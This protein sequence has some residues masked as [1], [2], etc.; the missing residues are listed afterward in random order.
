[1][2]TVTTV[3]TAENLLLL[4]QSIIEGVRVVK[5]TDKEV[6]YRSL[7]EMMQIRNLM[8]AKLGLKKCGGQG[9]FGGRRLTAKTS[10]GLDDC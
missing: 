3:F 8:R 7:D 4:E 2:S 10:K 9:L 6:E 5:Y 1:M